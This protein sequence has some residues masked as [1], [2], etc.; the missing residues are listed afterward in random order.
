MTW[1]R[2]PGADLAEECARQKRIASML[3]YGDDEGTL[4]ASDYVYQATADYYRARRSEDELRQHLQACVLLL[5]EGA[6]LVVS[7]SIGNE[8]GYRAALSFVEAAQ[9]L[10]AAVA[11]LSQKVTP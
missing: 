2:H 8:D 3:A 4:V 6:E 7:D 5:S 9:M 1:R 11:K 10:I